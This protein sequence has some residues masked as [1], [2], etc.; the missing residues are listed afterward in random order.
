MGKS[1][2]GSGIR[3]KRSM[4]VVGGAVAEQNKRAWTINPHSKAKTERS[5]PANW[6]HYTLT[7]N[8]AAWHHD[9]DSEAELYPT[10]FEHHQAALGALEVVK[11]I[12]GGHYCRYHRQMM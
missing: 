4:F 10:K 8:D 9:V 2:Y 5:T 11:M 12:E 6:L 1:S 7:S 3:V